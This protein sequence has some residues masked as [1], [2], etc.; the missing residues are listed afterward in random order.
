MRKSKGFTL[1]E[2]MVAVAV[3]AIALSAI[4]KAASESGANLSTLRDKTLAHWVAENRLAEM[5]AR[6]DYGEG[7]QKGSVQMA[8]REWY[9]QAETSATDLPNLD[10]VEIRVSDREDGQQWLTTLSGF[11]AD[12]ELRKGAPGGAPGPDQDQE[13]PPSE[14]PAAEQPPAG[15]SPPEEGGAQEVTE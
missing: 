2:V 7:S 1:L 12:P 4:I 5:Q 9:W 8:G 13:Q 10:K 6:E 15:G 3:L 11:L 14:Q